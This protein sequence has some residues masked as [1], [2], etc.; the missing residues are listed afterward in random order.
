MIWLPILRTR[1]T[2]S[3]LM[4]AMFLHASGA[5]AHSYLLLN[6]HI[7]DEVEQPTWL[8]IG[9]REFNGAFLSGHQHLPVN[10]SLV[11]ERITPNRYYLRHLD[12]TQKK[13]GDLRTMSFPSLTSIHIKPHTIHYAGDFEVNAKYVQQRMHST[14]QSSRVSTRSYNTHY[15]GDFKINA[16]GIDVNLRSETVRLACSKFPKIMSQHDL[17]IPVAGA[18]PI[19]FV[20]PCSDP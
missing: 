12:F 6:V 7:A 17:V 8:G 20:N 18:E 5:T 11:V 15:I 10:E 2:S 1:T 19:V 3:L 13:R 16:K 4:L 9:K 14:I